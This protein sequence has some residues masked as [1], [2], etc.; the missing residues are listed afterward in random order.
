M[1]I[2][3]DSGQR[4]MQGTKARTVVH[5]AYSRNYYHRTFSAN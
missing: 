5:Q 4:Q 1:T 3:A 2:V